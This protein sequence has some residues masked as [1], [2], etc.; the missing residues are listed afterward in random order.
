MSQELG[1]WPSGTIRV[2]ITV[3]QVLLELEELSNTCLSVFW[4][5]S[6]PKAESTVL[7]PQQLCPVSPKPFAWRLFRGEN[8]PRKLKH[9]AVCLLIM[10]IA[11]SGTCTLRC[12]VRKLVEMCWYFLSEYLKRKMSWLA[13]LFLVQF[14]Y[15]S[16]PPSTSQIGSM[17]ICLENVY[18]KL[19]TK[20]AVTVVY[21]T[22]D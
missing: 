7:Q 9:A 15:N 16:F 20:C 17:M 22:D 6:L 3:L 2:L 19:Q 21:N 12:V 8:F 14:S 13:V 11:C 1:S 5:Q 10:I 4:E 18:T